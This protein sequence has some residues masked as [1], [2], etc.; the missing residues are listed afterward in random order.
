M[1]GDRDFG[2]LAA[3]AFGD[4]LVLGAQRPAAGGGV[5]RGFAER[6]AQDR[7]ALA[8][9][10]PEASFAVGAADR[11]GS[12]RPTAQVL[13]GWEPVDVA[14]L[15]DDQHRGVAADPADLAQQLDALVGL[16]ALVDL[17]GGGGDLA[18]EVADQPE[19]AVEPPA[20]SVGQLEGGEELAAGLP[21]RSACSGRIPWR[22]SSA[23]T[24]FLIEVRRCTSV[25]RCRSRS[26]RSRSS[27][28][29][30]VRLGQQA[31]AQQVRERARVDRIGLHAR[32]G[33]RAGAQRVREV[34]VKAGVREQLREPLPAIG[35]LQRDVRALGVAEQLGERFPAVG[36][37]FCSVSSPCSSMI[38]IC[39][40]RRCRSM[41]TQRVGLVMVGPPLELSGRAA[42][43]RA[44]SK[45]ALRGGGPTS[46][47]PAGVRGPDR[48]SPPGPS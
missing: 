19:Q 4:P 11:S 23:C 22:A 10:V 8:G 1:A 20:G 34:H 15:G 18:V 43:I 9:D 39:E 45:L 36:I 28:R 12:V 30:D 17:A 32:G 25:A 5:L 42:G 44:V 35:R 7:G 40:R 27:R 48:R 31:G 37:R 41:P 14:D 2:D 46:C 3:A 29:G 13:G 16:R 26:R 38:A 33:D 6:P 21:N 24:R 47:H